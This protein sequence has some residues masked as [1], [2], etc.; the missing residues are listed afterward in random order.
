MKRSPAFGLSWYSLTIL[1]LLS[2]FSCIKEAEP[3]TEPVQLTGFLAN[4]KKDH[5]RLLLLDTRIEELKQLRKSDALLDQYISACL[6]RANSYLTKPM[7]ERVLTGPRLLSVSRELLIRSYCLSFAYRFTGDRKYFDGALNNL[8]AVC[9]FSDWNPSHFLDVAEMLHGVAIGYDWL[10]DDLSKADREILREGMKK[11]GLNEYEKRSGEWWNKAENNWNQVCNAGLI[12]G[13]LALAESDPTYAQELVPRAISNLSVALK[14]YA[15]DG[16]WYEGPAYW[17]YATEYLSY[18]MAA[19]ESSLGNMQGLEQYP[20]LRETG[21]V[22]MV[23]ASP[24]YNFL[25]FAD[26][27]ENSRSDASPAFMFL[28]KI[29]QNANISNYFHEVIKARNLLPHP[30]GVVWYQAPSSTAVPRTLDQFFKGKVEAV[31]FRSAWNDP[32]ALW[33]GIKGGINGSEHSHLDLGNFELEAGG[34]RWAKDLGS[35]DYNLPGYWTMGVN[36]QRWSYYRLNSFSH[37]VPLLGNQNQYPLAKAQFSQVELNTA[38]PFAILDLTEAYRDFASKI[39]R[40]VSLINQRSAFLIEDE[41]VLIKN[42]EVAWGMMTANSIEVQK[43]GKAMLRNSTITTRTLEAEVIS[44]Q[45]AEFSVESAVQ[46]APEK[47]NTGHSRLMLRLPNQ[48]GNVKVIVK[49]TPKS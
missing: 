21:L 27:G 7:L 18:G 47:L 32:K 42:T 1:A 6:S 39:T 41:F 2:F 3:V 33:L 11:H 25:N 12:V 10:Y 13:A 9:A 37:N 31:I 48:T 49:L 24:N 19:L 28:A 34:V 36:G 20:G 38:T 4:I 35:D 43:G 44:P 22:P 15:P 5:P 8:K 16:L 45:G 29:Y 40:K 30:L 46:K 26:A 17:S 14:N 23:C